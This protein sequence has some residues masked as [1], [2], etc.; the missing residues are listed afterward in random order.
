MIVL[1]FLILKRLEHFE[2]WDVHNLSG[3]LVPMPN[4]SD[5]AEFLPYIFL[6]FY[7]RFICILIFSEHMSQD[8]DPSFYFAQS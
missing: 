1:A 8:D 2:G 3:R 5:S 7:L 4:H 6:L